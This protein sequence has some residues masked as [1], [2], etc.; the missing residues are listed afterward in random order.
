MATRIQFSHLIQ[1]NVDV[2]WRDFLDEELNRALFLDDLGF[3]AY[4]LAE[5]SESAGRVQRRVEIGPHLNVPSAVK[6]V[7][8]DKFSYI[9]VGAF[10]AGEYRYECLPPAHIHTPIKATAG[11][12]VRAEPTP[13]GAT[14]RH[15]ELTCDIR[16]FGIGGM[17]E[18][19]MTKAG[20]ENY[21]AHAKALNARLAA[22]GEVS[23]H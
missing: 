22:R 11:G 4:R 3:T 6:N 19:A 1:C 9:E 13:D 18:N 12:V 16:M 10:E 5:R 21:D 15:I 7:I 23:N 17:L 8:G 14:V 2:F 20:R